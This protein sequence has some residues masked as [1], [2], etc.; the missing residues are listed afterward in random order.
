MSRDQTGIAPDSRAERIGGMRQRA[1]TK[2]PDLATND[3]TIHK[4]IRVIPFI[5]VDVGLE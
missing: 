2:E 4:T 5:D 3:S 1:P